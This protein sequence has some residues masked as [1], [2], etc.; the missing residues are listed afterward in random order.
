M[1]DVNRDGYIDM[2][3]EYLIGDAFGSHPGD[4]NWNPDADIIEDL[5]VN[6]LDSA[7]CGWNQGK[8]I[9]SSF[10]LSPQ[11]TINKTYESIAIEVWLVNASKVY[12]YAF[13]ITY[14]TE[15]LDAVDVEWGDFPSGPYYHKSW[16]INET[17]GVIEIS[18][19][20]TAQAPP[21]EGDGL[22]VTITFHHKT[23]V[24][25]DCLS[26][27]NL[28]NCTIE[29]DWWKLSLRCPELNE[30][31]GNLVDISNVEYSYTPIQGDVDFDG[32]VD[33]FDIMIVTAYYDQSQPD[34]YDLN[35]DGIID[36]FDLVY[37]AT[38]W[39]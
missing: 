31:T 16:H 12:D 32:D 17:T 38:N 22:L 24:W 4:D 29:L 19:A 23:I 25:K 39:G 18:L 11:F 3:D 15:I 20:E 2:I 14:N 33:I 34:A 9:W 26:W 36:I 27:T 10:G 30:I 8:D 1:G 5:E 37:V 21:A 35:C 6:I 13:N 28:L 7:R